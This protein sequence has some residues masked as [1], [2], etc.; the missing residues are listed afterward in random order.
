M[1]FAKTGGL[2]DVAGALPIQLAGMGHDVR[3]AM[4]KY[5]SVDEEKFH[6]LPILADYEVSLGDSRIA[7]RMKRTTFPDTNVPVYFTENETY[8]AR[9][10][11]Y[12]E[13][14]KDYPDNALR[15][16]FFCKAVLWLLKEIDWTP[17]IIQCN[18]WQTA[19]LPVYLR[20]R[21]EIRD[22]DA[23]QSIS[24]LYT[25][26]NLAYHGDFAATTAS[27]VDIGPDLFHPAGLEFYGRLN[28][29]KG[30]IIFAD[31]ISTVSQRYAEEIQTREYGA[32]LEGVLAQRRG[33]I[34][35]ILNG[36]DYR[37]WNPETDGLIP[38]HYSARRLAGKAMCK[39]DLQNDC[40]LPEDGS[41]PLIGIISRLDPQKGFDLIAD[42]LDDLL[43]LD[44]QMVLLGT[45]TPEYHRIFERAARKYKKK[46]SANLRFDNKLAHRIEAGSDIFLMPSRYEPC[47]L[48]QLYSLKYGTIPIV[49]ATGGL[50][51]SITNC[52]PDTLN[53]GT[54]T[55][56]V[57]EEYTADAMLEAVQ[58]A[59][60]SYGKKR[61]WKL[62][63]QNAML[64]DFSWTASARE[65]EKL[66]ERMIANRQSSQ[67]PVNLFPVT[68]EHH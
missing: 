37:I 66:F 22:H 28:L 6:L 44:V 25:I 18:D 61:T 20:T 33:S 48:N 65:Y 53:D 15:F 62:L 21:P 9:E 7:G 27:Q 4:P 51:D 46:L 41:V 55:G 17:D 36:I 50:A 67:L 32:G 47:G 38:T 57:F 64:Q 52:T 42:A 31:Q 63:V 59:L 16:A 58:R 14:G 24:V 12:G 11:L 13:N 29:M 3:V 54:A 1:P 8:F 26:H 34:S 56:F 43:S 45:G 49:R 23:F 35:G 39:K 10:G 68:D 30:G 60:A 5:G 40:E 19:L 2:A